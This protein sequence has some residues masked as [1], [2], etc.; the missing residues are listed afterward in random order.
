MTEDELLSLKIKE[1]DLKIKKAAKDWW[2]G[3]AKPV[4]GLGLF[5]DMIC[6]I[7]A[8][9]GTTEFTFD[10][11]ALIIMCADNGVVEEGI[12]QTTQEV[13][14]KVAALMGEGKSSVG[15]MTKGYPVDYYIYDIGMSSENTPEG[16]F[17]MKVRR[18]TADFL[19]EPAMTEAECLEAIGIGISVVEKCVKGG[20]KL[21]AT[22]E[23]GIGNTTTSTALMCAIKGLDCEKYTGK[24]AGLTDDGLQKKIQVISDGIKKYRG[25]KTGLEIK[26]KEEVF[27]MLRCL[28]GL[29]IAGLT[30]V[31]I[32]GAMYGIP[33]VIDGLISAVAAL[34]AQRL[35]PG[36]KEFMLASHAGREYA[37]EPILEE[38]SL[39]PVICADMALGEGT[40]AVMLFPLLEMALS[41][42]SD[43]TAFTAT[44][45]EQYERL[46]K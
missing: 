45:I 10:R 28:G 40:G 33:I 5:E 9:Y 31:F 17:D 3:I 24:G 20:C 41:L 44:E 37:M 16:V 21:I 1:P 42:Y 4:D 26:T 32:G 8:V 39:K 27:E 2:D 12:S 7:A 25:E 29:D 38:L 23:M 11:K 14:E 36:C 6:R 22:G 15:I 13:T 34:V 46:D 18:G 43:G 30:G 19:K 35:V